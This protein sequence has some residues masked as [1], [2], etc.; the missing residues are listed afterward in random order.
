M[1]HWNVWTQDL[2]GV[3]TRYYVKAPQRP[4]VA[5]LAAL[6]GW[7]EDLELTVK[8]EECKTIYKE[9]MMTGIAFLD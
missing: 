9:G 2:A 1:K 7:T 3:I 5:N 6:F 8:V 4:T